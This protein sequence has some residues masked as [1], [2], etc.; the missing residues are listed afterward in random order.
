MKCQTCGK[1]F[2]P[3]R[4][5]H[6]FCSSGCRW[7]GWRREQARDARAPLERTLREA[8]AVVAGLID[9]LDRALEKA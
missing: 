6:R 2:E 3:N 1:G 9:L 5:T 8:E 4:R 7:Q